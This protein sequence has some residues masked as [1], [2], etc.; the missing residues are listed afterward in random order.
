MPFKGDRL[1]QIISFTAPPHSRFYFMSSSSSTTRIC[2][3]KKKDATPCTKRLQK[4]L[5]SDFCGFHRCSKEH[6]FLE[7]VS[8]KMCS[9]HNEGK[10]KEKLTSQSSTEKVLSSSSKQECSICYTELDKTNITITKCGHTFCTDCI[11]KWIMK[12]K[13]CP[14]CRE[15]LR[16]SEPAPQ[17][18]HVTNLSNTELRER[19]SRYRRERSHYR[20]ER[21][22]MH[23]ELS[24][25]SE[26]FLSSIQE[27]VDFHKINLGYDFSETE[28]TTDSEN[29]ALE[30]KRTSIG[31]LLSK[32]KDTENYKDAYVKLQEYILNDLNNFG[33]H[34]SMYA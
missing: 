22:L 32:V 23:A 28:E 9:H 5:E 12:K 1:S 21:D 3:G 19:V 14:Y 26:M 8:G 13:T 25:R 4:G 24:H 31:K 17:R 18:D 15:E 20:N 2:Q 27:T 7:K 33:H 30:L 11:I 16:G 29:L 10:K 6:C 34:M